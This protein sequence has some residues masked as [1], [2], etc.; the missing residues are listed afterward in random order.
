MIT[1]EEVQ[2]MIREECDKLRDLLLAKNEAYG[3]SAI[4]PVR[5]FSRA[6]PVEQIRVRIDDKISRLM[7]GAATDAVPEDTA[8]DLC[9]YLVL[10]AI[11][12]RLEAKRQSTLSPP[13]F[14]KKKNR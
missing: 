1:K 11:A 5:I 13:Q 12:Q 6:S 10:L 8:A 7:R 4:D 9:G 2:A 14:W 3:N